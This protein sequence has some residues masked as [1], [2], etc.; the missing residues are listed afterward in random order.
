MFRSVV[1]GLFIIA[2]AP[3]VNAGFF[4]FSANKFQLMP[5]Q[6]YGLSG[7]EKADVYQLPGAKRPAVLFI[8]GGGWQSG[9]K[10]GYSFYAKMLADKG[11]ASVAINY[12]LFNAETRVNP[13]P[14]QIEDVQLALRWL[15]ANA[16]K[17][18]IDASR[19]CVWGDSAGAHLSLLLGSM[20][21][22]MPGDRAHLYR[23]QSLA[24]TCVVD[25]FGPTDLAAPS[26]SNMHA[27][28]TSMF[29]GQTP[30]QSPKIWHQASPAQIVTA[31][32]APTL[33][34]HGKDDAIVAFD[35]ANSLKAAFDKSGVA[36][37]WVP[38]PGG[39]WFKEPTTPQPIVD[40][41]TRKMVDY[42]VRKLNP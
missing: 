37:E 13:W 41:V 9:D 38:F 10:S 22:I 3:T 35:Q 27:L 14:A 12:R 19:L 31:A 26:L 39:H 6:T 32:S 5:D 17:Y 33:I 8:H 20:K 1:V 15:R 11:I 7:A 16:A 42:V 23:D 28:L 34:A 29:G 25:M 18:N 4:S 30:E 21:T 2:L 24:V 40:T 36:Y